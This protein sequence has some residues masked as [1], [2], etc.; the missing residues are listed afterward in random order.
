MLLP[1]VGG[2]HSK[3]CLTG[4]NGVSIQSP[5]VNTALGQWQRDHFPESVRKPA[6]HFL[7]DVPT[8]ANRTPDQTHLSGYVLGF[9]EERYVAMPSLTHVQRRNLRLGQVY[10]VTSF[11]ATA[12]IVAVG[13]L[14]KLS[15]EGGV[16]FYPSC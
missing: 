6:P 1:H 15:I 16:S 4:C 7:R 10:S 2:F 12:A 14:L 13:H 3:E 9:G 8:I 5:F 11:L